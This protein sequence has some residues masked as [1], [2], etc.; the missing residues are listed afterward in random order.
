M[1]KPTGGFMK[2]VLLGSL[3]TLIFSAA[4][5]AGQIMSNPSQWYIN[6]QIY[7]TRVFNGLVANSMLRKSGKGK[8]GQ[9][10]VKSGN[11]K[12]TADYTVFKESPNSSLAKLFAGKAGGGQNQREAQQLFDSFI[13]LYKQTAR[14]D[15]FPAND[16]AYAFEYFVV[17]NYHIYHDLMDLPPDKDPRTRRAR[18]GFDRINILNQKKLL[19]VTLSQERAIYNQFKT[20]L[21]ASPEVQ[22]M[23]DAQKQEA[24]ELFA[25]LFGVNYTGYMKGINDGDEE[26]TEQAR[27][28]ARQGLEKLLGVSVG[29]IKITS[30]GLEL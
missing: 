28:M 21:A 14:K 24:A 25:I 19:Q 17:N 2:K 8:T 26:L 12:G 4:P 23:T 7:S 15:G 11:S 29:Q 20:L 9:N 30:Y 27:Q 16:L 3:F 18:D 10:P 13:S 5:A 6:N 1:A 22:K